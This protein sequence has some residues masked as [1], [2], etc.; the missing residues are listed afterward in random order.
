[1]TKEESTTINE[2]FSNEHPFRGPAVK[3]AIIFLIVVALI[4]TAGLVATALTDSN[5]PPTQVYAKLPLKS[6]P[7]QQFLRSILNSS[8]P[9]LDLVLSLEFPS[10]TK[11]FGSTNYSVGN[12]DEAIQCSATNSTPDQLTSFFLL[13]LKVGGWQVTSNTTTNHNTERQLLAKFASNDGYYWQM[14]ITI[15][16]SSVIAFNPAT[17]DQVPSPPNGAIGYTVRLYELPDPD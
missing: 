5:P 3:P 15:R 9:P 14:G 12:Y 17:T 4:T 11:V 16:I 6:S 10:N 8:N 2:P 7:A 13:D 1:M